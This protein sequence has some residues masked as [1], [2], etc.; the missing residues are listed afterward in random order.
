VIA[1]DITKLITINQKAT[2]CTDLS[3]VMSCEEVSELYGF[4]AHLLSNHIKKGQNARV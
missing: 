1:E 2:V 4:E 3:E